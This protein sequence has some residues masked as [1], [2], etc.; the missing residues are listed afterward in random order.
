ME[1][2]PLDVIVV[3]NGCSDDTATVAAS[4]GG[5]VRVVSVPVASKRNALIAGDL[6]A[7]QFP[8][9]YVDADVEL[10]I[11][12]VRALTLAL[13]QPGILA[14]APERVLDLTDRPRL[15]RWYYN[16][17]TRLP[18]VQQGLFGRGVIAVNEEGHARIASLPPLLADDLAASLS[19]AS[20]ERIIVPGA[21]VTVHS[22]RTFADLMRRRVRAVEGVAQIEHTGDAPSS[23]ERTRISQLIEIVKTEPHLVFQ[24]MVFL[25][26]TLLARARAYR[27]V[28][29]H[30][31]SR[32]L[33][34]ESSRSEV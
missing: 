25:G 10:T 11:S 13:T 23:T 20:A 3:A 22:P 19:F 26:V 6:A 5:S 1:R 27:T 9:V 18:A 21:L 14:A 17:W 28:A 29:R 32:W 4:F 2:T 8:R 12:C 24:T 33:R 34:D 30:D 31:Y 16:V 15:I 7:R